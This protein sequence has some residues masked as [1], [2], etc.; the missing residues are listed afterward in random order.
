MPMTS[1]SRLIRIFI[2][3]TFRDFM[4]ERDELVKKIFPELR[5]RCK[6]RFVELLEVDLRWGITEEQSRQGETLRICLQEIDRCRPSSPVFFIGL[7]GERYGWIPPNDFYPT[8]VLEDPK[9]KWVQQHMDGK[10]VTELEILHGV[11]NNPK[12]AGR[13]FFY[14]R[15]DGYQ[16]RHWSEISVAYPDLKPE[17]FTNEK[18]KDPATALAKQEQLKQRIKDSGLKHAPCEYETPEQIAQRVLDD[19]WGEID[20]AFPA[21]EVPDALE[22]ETLEHRVFRDSRTRAY[23][24]RAGLF[25][26]LDAHARGVGPLCRVVKGS[27]GTGKSALLAA[28]LARHEEHVVFFHFI[29]GTSQSTSAESILHRLLDTLR[30]R[31]V[32]P[33]NS[34]IPHDSQAMAALLPQWLEKLADAGGG[35]LLFDALNQLDSPIDREL[36]WWPGEWPENVRV[37]FS[38]LPGDALRELERR[39]WADESHCITVPPLGPEEKEQIMNLYLQLFTK[40]LEKPL[41][42]RVLAATQTANPL[43]L[44]TVLDELRLRSRYEDLGKNLDLMLRCEDHT[45]LFVHVLKN[46]EHDFTPPDKPGLVHNALGFM[47][48]ARRGLAESE[49]LELLSESSTPAAQPLPR[50]YWSPLYLALEDSLVSRDG[51]LSFFHDYLRQAVLREYLDEEHEQDAANGR[52]AE[53]VATWKKASFGAS[54]RAY[55]FE[56][57]IGH[58]LKCRQLDHALELLFDQEYQRAA[59]RGLHD[60]EPV[61]RDVAAVRQKVALERPANVATGARLAVLALTGRDSLDQDLRETLDHM[62]RKGDWEDVAALAEAAA[63]PEDQV[64]LALRAVS[65]AGN[66]SPEEFSARLDRWIRTAGRDEWRELRRRIFSV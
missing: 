10:S 14:F 50:H 31:G 17:D 52:L 32:V 59:S 55:G 43:F 8:D 11:L 46:L 54:L 26:S 4:G 30:R 49:L 36:W 57:G 25:D 58:L 24:E 44:R 23:V 65:R 20:K 1:P 34:Q 39:G 66:R 19:L 18:E 29:G 64:L 37:V 12:M 62:A 53:T 3:S 22:R 9:L 33:A 60:P 6:A 40:V 35:V 48:A 47:G 16:K 51:Q 28:W 15:K 56:H 2:S 41:Q 61:L 42:Q 27:S 21:D 45:A 63:T 5:R 38:T 13:A 7:L